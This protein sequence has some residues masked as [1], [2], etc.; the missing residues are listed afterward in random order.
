[1][2]TPPLPRT[3]LLLQVFCWGLLG[4]DGVEAA[5]W[6]GYHR[7]LLEF[8][9]GVDP[10][11]DKTKS[12]DGGVGLPS[13]D[14]GNDDT[15]HASRFAHEETRTTSNSNSNTPLATAPPPFLR[16]RFLSEELFLSYEPA[17]TVTDQVRVLYR[18]ESVLFIITVTV[19]LLMFVSWIHATYRLP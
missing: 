7:K 15:R 4:A 9:W 12:L 6:M 16:P 3:L 10:C 8:D 18:M 5:N 19:R 17:A 11:C 2:V 14:D 1:M 13:K